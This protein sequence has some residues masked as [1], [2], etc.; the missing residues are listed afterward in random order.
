MARQNEHNTILMEK[1]II[2]NNTYLFKPISILEGNFN[3]ESRVFIDKFDNSYFSMYDV[4]MIGPGSEEN[5]CIGMYYAEEDLIENF[6]AQTKFDSIKLMEDYYYDNIWLGFIVESDERAEIYIIVMPIVEIED[7]FIVPCEEEKKYIINLDSKTNII[8]ENDI[9]ELLK[10]NDLTSLKKALNSLHERTSDNKNKF[11]ESKNELEYEN[12]EQI[13]GEQFTKNII[14]K[15]KQTENIDSDKLYKEINIEEMYKYITERVIGQNE[16]VKHV[17]TTFIMNKIKG[18]ENIEEELT[19]ILLTG[20]TGCGK[21]LIVETMLEYLSKVYH[22]N[23]PYAKTPTSQLTIAGYVG[24]DLEDII[25]TLVNNTTGT[26]LSNEDKIKF[27]EHNGIVFLDEIDKKGSPNNNDVSGRGVLNSLL[28]FL[29]G[30]NYEVGQGLKAYKFNT[31]NLN[32]F[33]AGAFTNVY[34][35]NKKSNIGFNSEFDLFQSEVTA[36]NLIKEGLMPNELMGR[37]HRIINLNPVSE[38]VLRNILLNSKISTLLTYQAKL[39]KFGVV[40][41][42]EESFINKIAEEAY[43]RKLGARSLKSL[44]EE[45]L[46]DVHWEALR[47]SIPGKIIVTDETVDNPKRYIYKP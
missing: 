20:P 40:L 34:E 44:I 1:I 14:T 46:S 15:I 26:F 35:N 43:K 17:I 4:E 19:R 24:S 18:N 5:Y 45:S 16:A 41:N 33:A 11:F 32:I 37:F 25:K 13:N 38:E 3:E 31:K 22:Q 7:K 30:S 23:F 28:E 6:P 12:I 47:R 27:V 21:T 8:S 2:N 9:N 42:W 39:K 10:I 36:E 29:S